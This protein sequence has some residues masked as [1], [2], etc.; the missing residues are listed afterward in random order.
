MAW[1]KSCTVCR[2]AFAYSF[3]QNRL[4]Q[5][6]VQFV[7][8]V[9]R[10]EGNRRPR[11]NYCSSDKCGTKRD[12]KAKRFSDEQHE[13]D[14]TDRI[15][16]MTSLITCY[17]ICTKKTCNEIVWYTVRVHSLVKLINSLSLYCR[18]LVHK[19]REKNVFAFRCTSTKT[20]RVIKQNNIDAA[21]SKAWCMLT[22][23]KD[24]NIPCGYAS[25]KSFNFSY[26]NI[27]LYTT[28]NSQSSMA[29]NHQQQRS[30]VATTNLSGTRRLQGRQRRRRHWRSRDQQVVPRHGERVQC[31]ARVPAET[32]EA[33]EHRWK[34]LPVLERSASCRDCRPTLCPPAQPTRLRQ[35]KIAPD[36][37][38]T[39]AKK[40]SLVLRG[41]QTVELRR[42]ISHVL[43]VFG[44]RKFGQNCA[45][46]MGERCCTMPFKLHVS[47]FQHHIQR[48]RDTVAAK[49]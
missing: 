11:R 14:V 16:S 13:N 6:A 4:C 46:L 23:K 7:T 34:R 17:T 24:S 36:E 31:D 43:N 48:S 35:W 37:L 5:Q 42:A 9:Q 39:N 30:L 40:L 20:R 10:T 8:G 22:M 47:P 21:N 1:S 2:P 44:I 26:S 25:C 38:Q 12:E 3:V 15:K 32:V 18:F 49:G 19:S 27:G 41:P 28:H 29:D 45:Y 33:D